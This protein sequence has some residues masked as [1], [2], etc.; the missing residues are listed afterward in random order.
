MRIPVLVALGALVPATAFAGD[1][2]AWRG[3]AGTGVS[4]ERGVPIEWSASENIT[5][6]TPL[7]DQ[8]NSTPIVWGDRVFVTQ[9]LEKGARR[10]VMCFDRGDGK[11]LWQGEVPFSG[12]EPTHDTNPYC[13]ASP[14]T[15]G[16]R[17]IAWHGSAGMVAYDFEGQELWRRDL[18]PFEHIWGNAA[19]P[20][21]HGELVIAH[22]GPGPQT[23]LAAFDKKT[24]QDVWRREL[25]DARGK[26]ADQWKGSWSTPVLRPIAG[27]HELL[28]SLPQQVSAFDPA[29]GA[30]RWTC[31][32]LG[33]LV[34]TSVLFGDDTVV[35]MSGYG[36]PALATRAGEKGDVTDTHRLWLVEGNP[37]RVGSGVVVGQH[38]FILEETGVAE[39]I[40]LA[41]GKSLWEE[42]LGA[43]SWSSM[44]HVDGRLYVIDMDGET[45][46]LAA[47]PEK[48][49]IIARNPLGELTRGSLAFSDG[50]IFIRTYQKLY[51]IG[52]RRR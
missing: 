2:P 33:D 15:D 18:G 36:G 1:W 28:V 50:Q 19:S 16:E 52:E 34:Y 17:V 38:I 24:G 4:D 23:I 46:V 5:W 26:D 41:T 48:C 43:K 35:A 10:T 7:P 20:V 47:N 8:G 37:Q 42:R 13:S 44:A 32:G 45:F 11:L 29:T 27:G 49:E 25:A 30:D 51:C 40:E 39:C 31:R 22:L 21:I 9:A 14:V 12:K 3:P 6:K